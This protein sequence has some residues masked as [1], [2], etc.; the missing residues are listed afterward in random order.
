[1]KSEEEEGKIQKLDFNLV[2]V[3]GG[4]GGGGGVWKTRRL[5]PH[6]MTPPIVLKLFD[7]ASPEDSKEPNLKSS[8]EVDA[9]MGRLTK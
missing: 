8:R 4:G 3:G 7:F 9:N 2:V 5:N 6:Q 1:M